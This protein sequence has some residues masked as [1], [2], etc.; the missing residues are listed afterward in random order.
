LTGSLTGVSAQDVQLLMAQAQSIFEGLAPTRFD[1]VAL[2][3]EPLAGA[4]FKL[5]HRYPFSA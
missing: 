5:L 4:A 2:V 1:G 3:G